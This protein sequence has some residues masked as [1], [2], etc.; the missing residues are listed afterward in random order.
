MVEAGCYNHPTAAT[1]WTSA[2]SISNEKTKAE[3]NYEEKVQINA[4][5]KN[6]MKLEKVKSEKTAE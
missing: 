4:T 1:E 6:K 2:D 3:F 5:K